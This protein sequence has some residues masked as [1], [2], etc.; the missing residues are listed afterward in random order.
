MN[1]FLLQAANVEDKWKLNEYISH[2]LQTY[3]SAIEIYFPKIQINGSKQLKYYF[4]KVNE[5]ERQ[6]HSLSLMQK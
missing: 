2:Y 1:I 6:K 4:E 3:S 5:I